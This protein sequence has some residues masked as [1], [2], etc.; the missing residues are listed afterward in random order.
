MGL[1]KNKVEQWKTKT[2]GGD[3]MRE[4]DR[5]IASAWSFATSGRRPA[6]QGEEENK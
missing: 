6:T 5:C 3:G 4:M 1:S 2:K